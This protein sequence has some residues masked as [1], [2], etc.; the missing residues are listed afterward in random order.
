[1]GENLPEVSQNAVDNLYGYEYI[2]I[3]RNDKH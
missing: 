3:E 2:T 1:M